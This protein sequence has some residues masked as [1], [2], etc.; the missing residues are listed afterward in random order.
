MSAS[1]SPRA[2]WRSVHKGARPRVLPL[3]TPGISWGGCR[4]EPLA[5]VLRSLPMSQAPPFALDPQPTLGLR[6][7]HRQPLFAIP[8]PSLAFGF[9]T[10][11]LSSPSPAHPWPS[12]SSPPASLRH[13]QPTLGLRLPR[14][15]PLFTMVWQPPL[16][17]S[18]KSGV[19]RASSPCPTGSPLCGAQLQSCP[20]HGALRQPEKCCDFINDPGSPCC[21]GGNEPLLRLPVS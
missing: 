17:S 7:P 11:S 12:A 18:A 2:P 13:P 14:R 4:E 16:P 6:L 15:Q 20:A 21:S 5:R 3:D 8:S 1:Q 10:A 9:L 19:V